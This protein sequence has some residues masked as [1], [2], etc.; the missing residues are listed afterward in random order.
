MGIPYFLDY[1]KLVFI[2]KSSLPS[3]HAREKEADAQ[4]KGKTTS[5]DSVWLTTKIV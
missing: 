5:W 1:S 4:K 2:W 3:D